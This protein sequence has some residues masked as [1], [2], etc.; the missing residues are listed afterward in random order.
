MRS[1]HHAV[2]TFFGAGLAPKAPGTVGSLAAIPLYLVLRR[3][4]GPVYL[5]IVAVLTVLGVKAA[6]VA[7]HDWGK[8]PGKVVI[9]EVVGMLL[10]LL[11]RPAGWRDIAAAFLIFRVLDIV[12]PPPVGNLDKG[13][14]G[15][16]GIM[17]DDV[18]AGLIGAGVLRLIKRLG[19]RR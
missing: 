4:P 7:E 2:A 9:D 3:L 8:D 11:E 19:W 5:A 15:G 18:A 16:I 13:L 6:D 17:A 14:S 10:T 12:K 1:I